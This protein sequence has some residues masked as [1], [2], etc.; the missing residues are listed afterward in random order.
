M[1]EV[2]RPRGKYTDAD[3]FRLMRLLR[4]RGG[5]PKEIEFTDTDLIVRSDTAIAAALDDVLNEPPAVD[6]TEAVLLLLD[7]AT[8]AASRG[9]MRERLLTRRAWERGGR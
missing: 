9:A 3:G 4:G 5:Q 1:P 8:T 2:R 6:L 7:P